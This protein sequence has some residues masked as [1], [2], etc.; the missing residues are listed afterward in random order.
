VVDGLE[1]LEPSD[2]EVLLV[3]EV[4]VDPGICND[5]GCPPRAPSPPKPPPLPYII[6]ILAW[7]ASGVIICYNI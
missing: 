4:E 5:P 7:M 6:C 3:P 2:E 1:A